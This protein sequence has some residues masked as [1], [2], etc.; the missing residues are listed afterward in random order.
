MRGFECSCA[1]AQ[2]LLAG[3]NRFDFMVARIAAGLNF[4]F[5][6]CGEYVV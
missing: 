1:C 6:G 5:D 3:F 4:G 2:T